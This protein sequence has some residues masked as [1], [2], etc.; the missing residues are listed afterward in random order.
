MPGAS[1]LW[2]VL[3]LF[4]ALGL[5][6]IGC[7]IHVSTPATTSSQSQSLRVLEERN[8]SL[9]SCLLGTHD[10]RDVLFVAGLLGTAGG[11]LVF[12][13]ITISCS[14]SVNSSRS[15]M[16]SPHRP[17]PSGSS[18]GPCHVDCRE[19]FCG[20]V[21][22]DKLPQRYDI[23]MAERGAAKAGSGQSGVLYTGVLS[24]MVRAEVRL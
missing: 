23:D 13:R 11:C 1:R 12:L 5:F 14:T 22:S 6:R 2:D 19:P 10:G 20:N 24:F 4:L 16:Y 8:N 18:P 17:V 21:V 15:S 3:S 7:E 9:T